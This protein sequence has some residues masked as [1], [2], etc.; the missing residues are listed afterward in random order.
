MGLIEKTATEIVGLLARREVTTGDLLDALEAR[1]ARVEPAV[2]ALPTLCFERARAWRAAD[3]VLH[4]LPVAIKDL[5]AV[6][7]VRTTYGSTVFADHVPETSDH[8]VERVEAA[9]GV[10]YAKTNTPEFGAGAQ[11]FNAVFGPT[12]NPW[13][14]A[15]TPAGSSGG[16]AV[17]LKTGT[18]WLAQGSDLGG[19]LRNPASFCGVAGLRPSVGRVPFGPAP[20]PWNNLSVEGP[21]ARTVEDLGLFLDALSG[22]DARE[23]LA[24]DAPPRP[25][26]AWAASP[27]L[28]KRV[29]FSPDLGG[30]TPVDPEVAALCEAAA[31]RFEKLGVTVER[32]SPDFSGAHACFQTLRALGFATAHRETLAT[33]REALKPDVVWNIEKG[34]KLTGED[35]AAALAARGAIMGRARAFFETYDLLLCPATIVPP[36]PV[37][38][39]YV[40]SCDGVTFETYV[41]WLAIVYAVT[42]TGHPALSLPCGFTARGLPVGLQMVGRWHGEG[43]LLA[44]AAALEAD[45]GLDHRPIDPR[46]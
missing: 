36:F 40:T 3:G 4:G 33:H 22:A 14:T 32:A 10:V 28:P 41:D 20:D 37:E 42:L 6:A 17:A 27:T 16:S 23:P 18:A 29:A 26:R 9:G 25:F 34:L 46:S 8:V 31:L 13:N 2:N 7:G 1:V 15:L 11:T 19:S 44:H 30:I 12:R 39:R 5:S 43:P 38:E 45:L 24:L 21:M 35:V